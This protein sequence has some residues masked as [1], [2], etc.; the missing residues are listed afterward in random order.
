M[1]KSKPPMS[2]YRMVSVA[3]AVA[4]IIDDCPANVDLPCPLRCGEEGAHIKDI[5]IRIQAELEALDW[6]LGV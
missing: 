1:G 3:L 2:P 5:R 6:W 4:H